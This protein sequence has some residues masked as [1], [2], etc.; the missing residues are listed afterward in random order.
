MKT[1]K[2]LWDDFISDANIDKA[3]KDFAKGKK[4]ISNYDRRVA[5]GDF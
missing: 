4:R 1:Y 2:N 3:I 5:N